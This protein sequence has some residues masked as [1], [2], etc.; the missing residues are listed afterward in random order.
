MTQKIE[1]SLF[2]SVVGHF[3]KQCDILFKIL[4]SKCFKVSYAEEIIIGSSA[5]RKF[6]I[7]MVSFCDIR[8]SQMNEH[9]IKYGEYGVALNK[10]W[11]IKNGLNPV[12]YISAGCP[13]FNHL[14][15]RMRQMRELIDNLKSEGS[16]DEFKDALL[17][18]NDLINVMRYMKNYE[19]DLA[20]KGWKV[21]KNYRY[22][23]E[24]EWRYVPDIKSGIIPIRKV[25][26]NKN[27]KMDANRAME[28]MS[29]SVLNFELSDISYIFIKNKV[30]AL[31][32]KEKLQ[33]RFCFEDYVLLSSKI[34][35]TAQ[36]LED[37]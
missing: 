4:S 11:A 23:N 36:V 12:S 30:M 25:S 7:P 37:F 24:H 28:G 31:K 6:G 8:L 3:T 18:Y 9:V 16:L 35:I 1:R 5:S 13:M 14:D 32:M 26:V 21:I 27:W 33:K 29:C 10:G 20:R 17:N 22:A 34:L 2:P 15:S 19:G